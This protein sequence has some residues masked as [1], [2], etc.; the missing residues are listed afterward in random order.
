MS[1]KYLITT[2]CTTK[3]RSMTE[4]FYDTYEG[5]LVDFAI[6]NIYLDG[7]IYIIVNVIEL[8]NKQ[9]EKANK[10]DGIGN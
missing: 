7:R 1:K 6:D 9:F 8:N 3:D 10:L 5:D 2:S 4:L